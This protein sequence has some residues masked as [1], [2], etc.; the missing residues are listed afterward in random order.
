MV[1]VNQVSAYNSAFTQDAMKYLQHMAVVEHKDSITEDIKSSL[2]MAPLFAIPMAIGAKNSANISNGAAV[3]VKAN[4]KFTQKI[5]NIP[6]NV[7]NKV[8]NIPNTVSNIGKSVRNIPSNVSSAAKNLTD[9]NAISRA[10]NV[11]KS[12]DGILYLDDLSDTIKTVRKSGADATDL[13]NLR[14]QLTKAIENGDKTD[15]IIKNVEVALQSSKSAGKKGIFSKIKS[16][17]SKPFAWL[18][19]KITSS[20]IYNTVKSTKVGGTI[21]SKLGSFAKIAKKGG[22]VF[23]IV[24]E[25]GAQLFGEVI[26]AF[27]NG[28][29]G[30]GMK[31]IAKSGV[32]V[33]ASTAGYALGASLGTKAGAA[34][35]TMICPG[36]GTAV[37]AV[38]GAV[39]GLV[40]GFIGSSVLSGIAKKITGKSENEK[41]QEQ[42]TEQQANMIAQDSASV[43]QLQNAVAQQVQYEIATGTADENTQKMMT[44]LQGTQTTGT[45]SFGS[46][47]NTSNGVIATNLDGSYDFSVPQDQVMQVAGTTSSTNPYGFVESALV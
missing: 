19:N 45:T 20:G 46:L 44:Y 1:M 5:K 7:A 34:I 9:G 33:A 8:K 37:G 10:A 26:P 6:S 3:K 30:A 13:I 18:G 22:A 24:M 11:F 15:D 16:V 31:Q 29:F 43:Q 4:T 14:N 32:Q 27:Q 35:G 25:G 47:T 17:A 21:I 23:D 12:G 28:G 41:I 40:G 42:Q 36:V 2:T 39:G 38:I